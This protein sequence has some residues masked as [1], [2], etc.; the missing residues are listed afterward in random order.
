MSRTHEQ[1]DVDGEGCDDDRIDLLERAR[2]IL[3]V[4]TMR[5]AVRIG[6]AIW[7][8]MMLLLMMMLLLVRER[9]GGIAR[10]LKYCRTEPWGLLC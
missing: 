7:M 8:V 10:G 4:D 9:M 5:H 2:S 1:E 6:A 3:R